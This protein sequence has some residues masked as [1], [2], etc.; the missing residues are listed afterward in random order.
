MSTYRNL[1]KIFLGPDAE[2]PETVRAINTLQNNVSDALI[3]LISNY[4][5]DS[6][7]LTN[8]SLAPNITNIVNHSL[9]KVLSGWKIVRQRSAASIY[10]IQDSNKSP[11]LSLWLIS[12]ANVVVD[13]EVF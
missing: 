4:Q 7:I 10:D 5:N 9:G 13:I 11:N 1:K 8:I 12:S 6:N 3:P 2:L